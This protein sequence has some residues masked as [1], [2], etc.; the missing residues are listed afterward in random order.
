MP[1]GPLREV[2]VRGA[3]RVLHSNEI[4]Y[5]QDFYSLTCLAPWPL[6]VLCNDSNRIILVEV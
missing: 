3:R 4:R 1:S 6:E 5:I 2:G